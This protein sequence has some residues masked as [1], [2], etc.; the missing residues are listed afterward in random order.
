MARQSPSN[1]SYPTPHPDPRRQQQEDDDNNDNDQYDHEHDVPGQR[2]SSP[3]FVDVEI[4]QSMGVASSQQSS[5][6]T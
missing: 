1:K 3:D 5:V 4:P 2:I 6:Y